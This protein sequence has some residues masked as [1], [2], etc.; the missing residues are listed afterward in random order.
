MKSYLLKSI[1]SADA[2]KVELQRLL[3]HE[4]STWLLRDVNEDT[5]AYFYVVDAATSEELQLP[6][7]VAD[8]SGRHYNSDE[9][10][11]AV[12]KSLQRKVGGDLVYA[13]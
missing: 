3:P 6:A 9:Q 13:P 8:I 5:M 1:S 10:V 4:G 12:L 2:A 11:L 7:V